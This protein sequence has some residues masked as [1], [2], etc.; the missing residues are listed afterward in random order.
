MSDL[1]SLAENGRA[2]MRSN[3]YDV[4]PAATSALKIACKVLCDGSKDAG[5]SGTGFACPVHGGAPGLMPGGSPGWYAALAGAAAGT[6]SDTAARHAMTIGPGNFRKAPRVARRA[7]PRL[8][9][10]RPRDALNT[11]SP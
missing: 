5:G 7:V 4:P 11:M 8:P 1:E 10:L 9:A 2:R 3:Q 6:A